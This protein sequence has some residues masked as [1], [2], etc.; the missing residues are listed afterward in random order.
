VSEGEVAQDRWQLPEKTLG[1]FMVEGAQPVVR[2]T[3]SE[4]ARERFLGYLLKK[5]TGAVHP[6]A[7]AQGKDEVAPWP[8]R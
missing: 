4:L 5:A 2:E 8:W 7:V 1:W 3:P 6:T